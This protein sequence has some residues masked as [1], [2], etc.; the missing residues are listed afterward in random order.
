MVNA[1]GSESR[2]RNNRFVRMPLRGTAQPWRC[3]PITIDALHKAESRDQAP[4]FW[5]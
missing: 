4:T 5:L 3:A 1:I 2:P